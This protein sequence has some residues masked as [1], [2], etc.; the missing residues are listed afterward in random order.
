[1][2][3]VSLRD[4]TK[5]FEDTVAVADLNLEVADGEFVVLVGP[6]GSGKTTALRLVAG[7]E[8]PTRGSILI[9]DRE[10]TDV[11][12]KDRDIAMVFQNY[13][14]YPHMTVR[15][16]LAFGLRMRRISRQVTAEAVWRAAEL[17]SLEDLLERRP[18]QLSGGQS[19]RVAVG[20]A[21]V[22]DPQVFLFDEPLAHL[23]AQLRIQ[24]RTEIIRF[25]R[26]LG[27][28]M[29]YVT[30][31]QVEAM[32][33]GD[34]IA[35]MREGVIQQV[36]TPLGL[37]HRPANRF[38]AG[39]IGSPAMNFVAGRLEGSQFV[40]GTRTLDIGRSLPAG[41][42]LLG[43]RPEHLVADGRGVPFAEAPVEILERVGHETI[44]YLQ[45][46]GQTLVT[47]LPFDTTVAAGDLVPLS[48]LPQ[49][50]HL[51]AVGGDQPRLA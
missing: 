40:Y 44:A 39:F 14:L 37:Y 20:R 12:P 36:D 5:Q 22:R 49:T 30:H 4:L 1:M 48:I 21:I 15:Q 35:I 51:F 16:N 17:L 24:M 10:V 38:V 45:F 3:H 32:T 9:G 11:P 27:T 13:A 46:A 23:D 29:I 43:V 34:R 25:Q 41:P 28:T 33:M 8:R 26:R 31:D 7:L 2:A 50:W 6:S 47:R 19:Q 42:A 18:H